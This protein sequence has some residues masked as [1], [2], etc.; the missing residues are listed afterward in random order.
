LG[1]ARSLLAAEI[2][3]AR[4]ARAEAVNHAA[5][6]VGAE[7][8]LEL[9]EPPAW[10]LPARHALGRA[11]LASGRAKEARIVFA[12]D[13]E[14]NPENA[15]AMTGLAAAQRW[16]GQ[17]DVADDLERRAR[18]AWARADIELPSPAVQLQRKR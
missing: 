13:L 9:D 3:L 18:I 1:V 15:V 2:A 16:L 17:A 10:Q 4:G 6:A 11:L 12:D 8:Q 14:R 7:D 5:A